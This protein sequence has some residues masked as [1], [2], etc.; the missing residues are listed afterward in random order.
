MIDVK[1]QCIVVVVAVAQTVDT[2]SEIESCVLTEVV[3]AGETS[4][5]T[6]HEAKPKLFVCFKRL[7]VSLWTGTSLGGS[8]LG[9]E[10]HECCCNHKYEFCSHKAAVYQAIIGRVLWHLHASWGSSFVLDEILAIAYL[11]GVVMSVY[12]IKSY[13]RLWSVPG[14]IAVSLLA[15]CGEGDGEVDDSLPSCEEDTRDD[16]FVVGIE[17]TGEA[18][19]T[20]AIL[21]SLPAPP[22]KGDNQWSVELRDAS[23][24]LMPGYALEVA[25]FMPDHGHGTGVT[26][27]VTDDGDGAYTINPVNFFMPGYWETTITV[28]DEGPTDS[29]DDDIDIDS[30]VFKF[31]VE[32]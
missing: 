5:Y 24:T 9:E 10:K 17:K 30:M 32:G 12:Y 6:E 21:D 25:P 1:V 11:V 15:S 3:L 31:C 16:E 4:G 23:G 7:G 29:E 2:Q 20:L 14:M 18:G 28:V 26:A 27:I 13:M 22:A 19:F 8:N